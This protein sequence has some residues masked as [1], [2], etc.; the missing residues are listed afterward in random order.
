MEETGG[1]SN[2]SA[3]RRVH[4]DTRDGPFTDAG[5]RGVRGRGRGISRGSSSG[6]DTVPG[7]VNKGRGNARS[8]S[9]TRLPPDSVR[10]QHHNS[11]DESAPTPDQ[12]HHHQNFDAPSSSL[13][14]ANRPQDEVAR[15]YNRHS[16]SKYDVYINLVMLKGLLLFLVVLLL[17]LFQTETDLRSFYTETKY[18]K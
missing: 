1:V 16:N 15:E 13:Q 10:L 6:V 18:L 12:Q 7:S 11:G 4:R 2:S 9:E 8:S 14:G 17:L 5:P 3:G